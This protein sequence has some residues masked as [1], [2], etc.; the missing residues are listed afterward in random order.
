MVLCGYKK[1]H[2]IMESLNFG[3]SQICQQLLVLSPWTTD[4]FHPWNEAN[5]FFLKGFFSF[6]RGN[7]IYQLIHPLTGK[8]YIPNYPNKRL[9]IYVE[10]NVIFYLKYKCYNRECYLTQYLF[11]PPP[12]LTEPQFFSGNCFSLPGYVTL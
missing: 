3:G 12:S 9:F 5:D 6:L 10:V 7:C 11:H 4:L 1:L 8:L 2:V